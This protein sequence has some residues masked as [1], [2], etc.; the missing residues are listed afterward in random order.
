MDKDIFGDKK[1][2][3]KVNCVLIPHDINMLFAFEQHNNTSGYTG[4]SYEKESGKYQIGLN[5]YGK[6]R[7][8]GHASDPIEG[9]KLYIQAKLNYCDE[10]LSKYDFIGNETKQKIKNS[11]EQK[12][13]EP[14]NK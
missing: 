13:M 9:Y 8:V 5:M 12:L 2:Y 3:S 10:V 14:L 6:R 7:Y 11:L 4:V 1:T